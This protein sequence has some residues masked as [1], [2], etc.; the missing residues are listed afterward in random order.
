MTVNRLLSNAYLWDCEDDF[1]K[2]YDIAEGFKQRIHQAT[3]TIAARN[4]VLSQYSHELEMC[5]EQLKES[6]EKVKR[7]RVWAW[8]SRIG[9]AAGA[10]FAVKEFVDQ[11]P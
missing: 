1:F 4:E 7:M 6:G 5:G 2:A 10:V 11:A 8:I 9:L 3:D